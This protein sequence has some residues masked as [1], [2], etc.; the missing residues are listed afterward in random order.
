MRIECSEGPY[1]QKTRLRTD[2]QSKIWLVLLGLRDGDGIAHPSVDGIARMVGSSRRTVFLA[3][4][5]LKQMA[6]VMPAGKQYIE[7]AGRGVYCRHVW[8]TLDLD[9]LDSDDPTGTFP[10]KFAGRTRRVAALMQD[11]FD[12][13]EPLS[14][15]DTGL[16]SRA[17]PMKDEYLIFLPNTR[18]FL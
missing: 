13:G 12:G 2:L 3:L 4:S 14:S 1:R 8:G 16:T 17:K 11:L 10:A 5:R 7:R 18:V 6:L 9:A 15:F